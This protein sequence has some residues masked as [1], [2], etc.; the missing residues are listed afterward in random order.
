MAT[1]AARRL[2]EMAE[3]AAGIV[4]IELLAAAQGIEFHR[5]LATSVPLEAVHAKIR[6]VVAPWDR[7]RY[8]APDIA[9]VK[10][11]VM[12]GEVSAPVAA[13]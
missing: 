13:G 8:F 2:G 11:M 4:A 9:A 1:W 5:P 12:G 10:A 7:D 6:A 3:N